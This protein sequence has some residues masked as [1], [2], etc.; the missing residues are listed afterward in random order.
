MVG[1]VPTPYIFDDRCEPLEVAHK[2]LEVY[3][4]GKEERTR[5]GLEGMKWVQSDESMMSSENMSKNVISGID[6][7][8]SKWKPKKRFQ[9]I[10]SEK[11][12]PKK[13]QHK[14]I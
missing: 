1:S 4:L 10:K 3:N 12:L 9:I 13:A 11:I 2:I 8:L 5:R 6:E 7:T 14:L